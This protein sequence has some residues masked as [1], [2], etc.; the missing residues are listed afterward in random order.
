MKGTEGL[1][2]KG[3][4]ENELLFALDIGTRS[5]VG[6]VG[7][8]EEGKVRI[9]AMELQPHNRRAMR[10]GQI[11]DIQEVA[12]QAV[13]VK[14]RLESK[15][16]VSLKNVYVAAAGRALKT[17]QASFELKT[18]QRI[19][20][21]EEMISKLEAGAISR[22]EEEFRSREGDEYRFFMVGYSVSQYYLEGYPMSSLLEHSAKE[23]R[24]DIIATF[25]PEQVVESLYAAMR[26]AG[27]TIAG[28]TLEPIAAI[29]IAIPEKIR[30]L[31]LVL[32][33]IGAGTSDIA[34]CRD[35]SVTGYTMATMAG[36]EIT[37]ELMREYLL[38]FDTAEQVKIDAGICEEV[39]FRN[40]LGQE[41]S[42]PSAEIFSAV[43][44]TSDKLSQE[45]AEKIL[46]VN[47]GEPSA[48]FLAGGGSR[49][50]GLREKIAKKLNMDEKRVAVAGDFYRTS[51]ISE[52]NIENPEYATPLGILVSAALGLIRDN[53][54]I[55]LN[56][57]PARLFGSGSLTARDILLMNGY[58]YRDMVGATGR[59]LVV[60]VDGCRR[61]FSGSSA[62][63]AILEINREEAALTSKIKP[64]DEILFI[65]AK[66]GKDAERRAS[67]VPGYSE[68][69]K[70]LLNGQIQEASVK[71]HNGDDLRLISDLTE[72]IDSEEKM[73]VWLNGEK[74]FLSQKEDGQPHYLMDMLLLVDIDFKKVAHPVQFLVNG[75][76]SGFQQIL[77]AGDRIVIREKDE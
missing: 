36:D 72:S 71:L 56:G 13:F 66:S 29:N 75:K 18:E 32:V 62:I 52:D 38:D 63:P 74:V 10:D 28:M 4:Q 64:G 5:L 42:V 23:I 73:V 47:G 25:L 12:R 57:S 53:H 44:K 30:L 9:L 15:L 76:E 51:C 67:Q 31:N 35:G 43:D 41:R 39:S 61:G 55:L 20:V 19:H 70:V 8:L 34:A 17:C 69:K 7:R 60:M 33:D 16:G 49:L 1:E 48:L 45:I 21:D 2:M 6:V 26:L 40:I 22:A 58:T 54:R 27:L 59:N 11:E 50:K 24:A 68:Q 46:Q 65:P 3:K 14:N 77:K 37:E